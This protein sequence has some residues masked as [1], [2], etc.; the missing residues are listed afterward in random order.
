M[1]YYLN[2]QN[3]N[4][5]NLNHFQEIDNWQRVWDIS[6]YLTNIVPHHLWKKTRSCNCWLHIPLYFR[7]LTYLL[8]EALKVVKMSWTKGF[9][10]LSIAQFCNN[11][12]LIEIF[13]T[14][15][16][17]NWICTRKIYFPKKFPIILG[18]NEIKIPKQLTN[19]E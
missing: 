18:E 14:F 12:N 2:R 15:S 13:E 11:E 19:H 17:I 6:N 10:F 4:M 3:D 5:G 1:G 9:F 8:N 7:L 16:K